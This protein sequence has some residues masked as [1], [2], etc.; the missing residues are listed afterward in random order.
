MGSCAI[1]KVYP[2]SGSVIAH[3]RS[4]CLENRE[5]R[6]KVSTSK[7]TRQN[8]VVGYPFASLMRLVWEPD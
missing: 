2:K 8:G 4:D 1:P 6:E 7:C 5:E 3:H